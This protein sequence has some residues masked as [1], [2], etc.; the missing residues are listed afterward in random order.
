MLIRS[1]AQRVIKKMTIFD[2][3]FIAFGLIA[4]ISFYFFFRRDVVYTTAR[5]KVTDEIALYAVSSPNVEF[6]SSFHVGDTERDELGRVVSEITSIETY[7]IVPDKQVVYLDIKLKSVYNPRTK[8]HSVRGKDIIFGESFDF[9]F[10]KVRFKG[11]IV[12]F[13]GFNDQD[14]EKSKKITLKAQLRNENRNYSDVYGVP[15]FIAKS[16]KPGD[17]VKDSK[18]N[19]LVKIVEVNILPAKRVVLNNAGAYTIDDP[20]LK[21][22]FYTMEISAKEINGKN[23]MFDYL[24][25]F[26]GTVVPIN[27]ENSSLF[28]TITEILN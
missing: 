10:T 23:Y 9:S 13:E 15:E 22:V 8:K 25:V 5:V 1:L 17:E 6:A 18:G 24:P 20:Y 26:I 16:V 14:S 2:W 12:D 3:V 21:D 11:I 19:T 7:K 28:P 4:F 27:T